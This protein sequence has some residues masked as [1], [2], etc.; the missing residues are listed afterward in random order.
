ML[1]LQ[2]SAVKLRAF[3]ER[4]MNPSLSHTPSETVQWISSFWICNYTNAIIAF[5][6]F[7]SGVKFNHLQNTLCTLPYASAAEIHVITESDNLKKVWSQNTGSIY[8]LMMLLNLLKHFFLEFSSYALLTQF[9]SNKDWDN[10]ADTIVNTDRSLDVVH[11]TVRGAKS[12]GPLAVSLN[13]A[14]SQL[15]YVRRSKTASNKM[16]INS[17][18][19]LYAS[20]RPT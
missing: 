16:L 11:Y 8:K 1:Q 5:L 20:R 10:S 6:S 19:L 3:D 14:S 7:Y 12:M 13:S 4:F 9:M 18:R 2:Q 15:L 17:E